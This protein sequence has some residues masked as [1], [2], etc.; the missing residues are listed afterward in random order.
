[1]LVN[2]TARKNLFIVVAKIGDLIP[3]LRGNA[4][5][6]STEIVAIEIKERHPSPCDR[7][8]KGRNVNY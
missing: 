8:C 5:S 4:N 2:T 3:L 1:M 6:Q 7:R